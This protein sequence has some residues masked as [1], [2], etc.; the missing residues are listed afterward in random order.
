M[1]YESGLVDRG[2]PFG[3][4]RYIDASE[5]CIAI[6][7]HKMNKPEF[8]EG[9]KTVFKNTSIKA[10]TQVYWEQTY[11]ETTGTADSKVIYNVQQVDCPHEEAISEAIA[12]SIEEAEYAIRQIYNYNYTFP[13]GSGADAA[14]ANN[15]WWGM[16]IKDALGLFI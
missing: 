5:L 9:Q 3:Y 10:N 13:I 6:M 7:K 2:K 15:T 12:D 4:E 11:T 8:N 1:A 14:K 16:A